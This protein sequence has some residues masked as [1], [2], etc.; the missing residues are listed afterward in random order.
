[1]P[2]LDATNLRILAL[3]QANARM[4]NAEIARMVQIAP[5]AVYERIRK[6]EES[7]VIQGYEA[8]IDPKAL[9]LGV[10]AFIS[11]RSDDRW[12]DLTTA[13][14]LA[15]V[16]E[17]QEIHGIAGEDCYL[18]KV[19]AADTEAL[20]KMLGERFGKVDAV[21]STRTTIVLRT[22][23]ETAKLPLGGLATTNVA[24]APARN[25]HGL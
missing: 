7:G 2:A 1:M 14:A 22:V 12:G 10:T 9:G 13:E 15:R 20:V 4:S 11:V 5:S 24:K 3:L 18:V 19:R 6:L 8:R 17:V 25:G 21:R 23:K 16:P